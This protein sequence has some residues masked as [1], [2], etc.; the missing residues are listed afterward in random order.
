MLYPPPPRGSFPH[1]QPANGCQPSSRTITFGMVFARAFYAPC[2]HA[3]FDGTRP[4]ISRC[5]R[6]HRSLSHPSRCSCVHVSASRTHRKQ[7]SRRPHRG[8]QDQRA[9]ANGRT[10]PAATVAYTRAPS[11][12]FRGT[13]ALRPFA[14][15]CSTSWEGCG[16]GVCAWSNSSV[17]EIS[18]LVR[19][20]VG[21]RPTPVLEP[22]AWWCLVSWRVNL[23]TSIVL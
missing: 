1:T 19:L 9:G 10:A 11:L 8:R 20:L 4:R 5:S 3:S 17:A 15:L 22:T 7:T 14:R 21:L 13:E 6:P 18:Q 12:P 16:G 23:S 2:V